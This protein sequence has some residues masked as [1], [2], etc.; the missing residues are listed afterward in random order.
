MIRRFES[1]N[2]L[3]VQGAGY[4]GYTGISPVYYSLAGSLRESQMIHRA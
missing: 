4:F 3:L 2:G 1:E